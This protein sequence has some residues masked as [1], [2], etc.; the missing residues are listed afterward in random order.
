MIAPNIPNAPD[1]LQME[2]R[3]LAA[4][5]DLL[6]GM[7]Q[8]D[9]ARKHGVSRTT[10][11]RWSR[12]LRNGGMKRLELRHAT[13]RPARLNSAQHTKLRRLIN[14]GCTNTEAVEVIEREFGVKYDPD[15][16]GRLL[17]KLGLRTP[18][19]RAARA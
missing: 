13:G 11:S 2:K 15:H 4:G 9:V 10:T 19:R 7:S 8:A 14:P 6:A 5:V 18:R 12:A 3:R 1:R 16:V 17:V